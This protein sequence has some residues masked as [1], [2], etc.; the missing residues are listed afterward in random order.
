MEK[1]ADD[2]VAPLSTQALEAELAALTGLGLD[3]GGI[4][5]EEQAGSAAV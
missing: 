3:E 1:G 5:D 2:V 4:D